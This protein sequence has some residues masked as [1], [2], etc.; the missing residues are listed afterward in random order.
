MLPNCFVACNIY[1]SAGLKNYRAV[2]VNLL[3]D[4]QKLCA[5]A[6][7]KEKEQYATIVH[8]FTDPSYD[9]SSFH[10]SGSPL[11]VTAVASGLAS[12]AFRSIAPLKQEYQQEVRSNLEHPTVGLVDHITILPLGKHNSSELITFEEWQDLC[13]EFKI[14][15][16]NDLPSS[17]LPSG[18]VA[19]TI[20]QDLASSFPVEVLFYGYAHFMRKPLAEVRRESTAFFRSLP[21]TASS[22]FGKCTIGA[23]PE[24][25]ENYNIRLSKECPKQTALSL[26]KFLRERDGGLPFVEAL[27]L[28]YK[29]NRF[30]VACNLLSPAV[31]SSSHIDDRV[32]KFFFQNSMDVHSMVQASYR[33]GTTEEECLQALELEQ[34]NRN[35]SLRNERNR[36][37]L[38]KFKACFD[39]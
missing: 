37:V 1:I 38:Q 36:M 11:A 2:L 23:P 7:N 19:R 13:G 35:S 14:E 12:N 16:T 22:D 28:P 39:D 30:E 18:W 6:S 4:A 3:E 20:G 31:T 32:V 25:V 26:T 15:K 33:V 8:A 24:F 27:T 34:G 9:R 17:S 5:Q 10:I 21:K 29:H